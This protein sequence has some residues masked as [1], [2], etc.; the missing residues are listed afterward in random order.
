MGS[1]FNTH[2]SPDCQQGQW[3]HKAL[4]DGPMSS[5]SSLVKL[6][7]LSLRKNMPWKQT[8]KQGHE[9]CKISIFAN[10]P[11]F[12]ALWSWWRVSAQVIWG[13]IKA[14]GLSVLDNTV[15]S[16]LPICPQTF[17]KLVLLEKE[18]KYYLT[19]TTRRYVCADC[20]LSTLGDGKQLLFLF[21]Q[22]NKKKWLA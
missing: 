1:V 16:L 2:E 18:R 8:K 9:R 17:H 7:K 20:S 4:R 3:Q 19:A 14:F 6:D 22:Q 21:G 11:L 12:D 10:S 5:H 13:S 15:F